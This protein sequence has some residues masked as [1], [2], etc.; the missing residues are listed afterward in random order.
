MV[1][2]SGFLFIFLSLLLAA[3]PNPPQQVTA[4]VPQ[5]VVVL[6][7]AVA[8][9]G[10]LPSDSTASG[11][12]VI[13]AGSQTL[14]GTIQVLTRGTSQSAETITTSEGTVELVY[15]N[16]LAAE[17]NESGTKQ[18]YSLELS[19]SAQ[20]AL[21]P[22]PILSA[23][24]S[25]TDSVIQY[26]GLEQVGGSQCQHIRTWNTFASQPGLQT[27]APFT[28]R[29]IWIDATTNLP[30]QLAYS[31]RD[32][33]GAVPSNAVVIA[34]SD[35][36]QEGGTNYPFQISKT[37]NGVPWMSITI[38]SVSFNTGLTDSSFPVQ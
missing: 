35:Y 4:T 17:T 12:V 29:D 8:A 1:F 34:Y 38:S 25:S 15:S 14:N 2:R 10:Y 3:G 6:Q 9:L 31:T 18:A 36:R 11:L 5:A 33:T 22:L 7:Q 28:I 37:V 26:V 24:L 23:I 32:G 16:G 27:L 30:V 21:F 13:T 20:S 19:S